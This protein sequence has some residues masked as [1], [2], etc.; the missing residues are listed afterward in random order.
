MPHNLPKPQTVHDL[1]VLLDTSQERFGKGGRRLAQFFAA[2]LAEAA[3]LST[4]EVAM[5][6][7]AP[8]T[9]PPRRKGSTH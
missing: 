7:D 4:A 9:L 5:R 8:I 2:N 1:L 3:M 6:P